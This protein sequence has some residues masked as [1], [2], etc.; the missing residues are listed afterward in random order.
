MP[1]TPSDRV[2]LNPFA[3]NRTQFNHARGVR[4][5]DD[6]WLRQLCLWAD[7]DLE[8]WCH[9]HSAVRLV[10]A[11]GVS[12]RRAHAP[13]RTARDDATGVLVTVH[14]EESSQ[15]KSSQ[16]K[17][18]QVKSSQVKSSHLCTKKSWS[19]IGPATA[20][21]KLKASRAPSRVLTHPNVREAPA[22]LPEGPVVGDVFLESCHP[23][24]AS[25]FGFG[26]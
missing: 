17:S 11:R 16:V 6:R 12:Q 25:K 26:R 1:G 14:E 10:P 5:M 22:L 8:Q 9:G 7:I 19:A 2:E 23:S 4:S 3:R 18:S 21:G 20:R 13:V 24:K 15:V